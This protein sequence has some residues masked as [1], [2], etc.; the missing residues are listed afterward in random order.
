LNN[1]NSEIVSEPFVTVTH[2]RRSI[3]ERRQETNHTNTN[4][5]TARFS[6]KRRFQP[7]QN[8]LN[9]STTSNSKSS[10]PI[11]KEEDQT[12]SVSLPPPPPSAV[13]TE[14]PAAIPPIPLPPPS[15]S[16]IS[17]QTSPRLS[18][19]SS[20]SSL[21]SLLKRQSKVAP[22]VVFLNKSI[23]IELNDVSFGFDMETSTTTATDK[24]ST[25]TPTSPLSPV[26]PS[27]T[28]EPS[29]DKDNYHSSPTKRSY[30]Q[31]NIRSQPF[32]SSN[33]DT[34][35]HQQRNYSS[36]QSSSSYADPYLLLQYQQQLAYMNYFRSQYLPSQ[37]SYVLI[38]TVPPSSGLE[39][40]PNDK[41]SPNEQIH[42][43]L[44]VYTAFPGQNQPIYYQQNKKS[45]YPS[46]YF[47]PATH[48]AY[49]QPISTSSVIDNKS[50]QDDTDHDDILDDDEIEHDYDK[51]STRLFHR[52]QPSSSSSSSHIMS[53]ALQLVYSQEKFNAQT[54]RF[55]LD[56]ITA[57]LAMKWT[58]TVDHYEQGI[59]ARIVILR[60][61]SMF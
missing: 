19:H 58:E 13:S 53:N 47:Y 39:P 48:P 10:I 20:S 24:P 41:D 25:P 42:E 29:V 4:H 34:R 11:T 36:S 17:E 9:R 14:I 23:D 55:N 43:P 54:D 40:N 32:H 30:P 16:S 57:Y 1:S 7:T 50:Q 22:P 31:R 6:D 28:S 26:Q 61:K 52:M 49:F 51:S 38:P 5:R 8:G 27:L 45:M 15:S 46:Q 2:R 44:F 60:L 3:K 18:S 56:Q 33:T 35:S 59:K 37:S 12:T 21:S